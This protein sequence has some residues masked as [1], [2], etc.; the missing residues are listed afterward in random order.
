[1]LTQLCFC[2]WGVD[3][4]TVENELNMIVMSTYNVVRL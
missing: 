4:G 2:L 1:M 3:L